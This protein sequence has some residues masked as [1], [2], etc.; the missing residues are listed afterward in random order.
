VTE[1]AAPETILNPLTGELVPTS[2]LQRVAE[3]VDELRRAKGRLDA[4]IAALTD[5]VVEHSRVMGTKTFQLPGLTASVGADTQIEWDY[6]LLQ[7]GLHAAGCPQDRIDALVT[8]K[9]EYG[10]NGTVARQLS[11]ANAA[12]K[13]AIEAAQTRVPKRPYLSIKPT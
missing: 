12:Y 4:V 13:A 8:V 3:T 2:D 11:G 9:V 5:A 10:V 7:E 6:G 1:I